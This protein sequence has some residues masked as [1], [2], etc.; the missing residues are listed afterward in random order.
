M[1]LVVFV[2][3]V[4]FL[5]LFFHVGVVLSVDAGWHRPSVAMLVTSASKKWWAV[6]LV[7]PL[8]GVVCSSVWGC[9]PVALVVPFLG[10]IRSAPLWSGVAGPG[11]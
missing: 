4:V 3:G 5:P 9:S 6:R 11:C 7:P 8:V 2:L 1:A 10:G